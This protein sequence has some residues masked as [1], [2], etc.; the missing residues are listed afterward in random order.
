M[1]KHCLPKLMR[2]TACAL[3]GALVAGCA[4][5]P[6]PSRDTGIPTS[7]H[8][9]SPSPPAATSIIIPSTTPTGVVEPTP[10]I[11]PFPQIPAG[12]WLLFANCWSDESL[13]LHWSVSVVSP[14]GSGFD[15]IRNGTGF[16]L[17]FSQSHSRLIAVDPDRSQSRQSD[18]YI[19]DLVTGDVSDVPG[20]PIH[21]SVYLDWA[22]DE[23]AVTLNLDGDLYLLDLTIGNM[24]R[25]LD[26]EAVDNGS[27][28]QAVWSPDRQRI[29]INLG[30]AR[31]G[32]VDQRTGIYILDAEC[33]LSSGGCPFARSQRVPER[34]GLSAWSPD[35]KFIAVAEHSLL[36]IVDASELSTIR[37]IPLDSAVS[38][39]SLAWSSGHAALAIGSWGRLYLLPLDGPSI[40]TLLRSVAGEIGPIAWFV[41][42]P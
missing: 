11:A 42:P 12:E 20:D 5:A 31:S 18:L 25:M 21:H 17:A 40:P 29:T 26:C 9:P 19:V 33:L 38:V 10:T 2:T 6:A 28:G 16:A 34:A 7:A 15:R 30:F 27:C 13:L 32:P 14:D 3:L 41:V 1:K 22:P 4:V 8:V 35:G 36:S 24:R 37:E 23:N 39:R